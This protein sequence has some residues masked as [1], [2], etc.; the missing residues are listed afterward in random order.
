[1]YLFSHCLCS[2]LPSEIP[3]VSHAVSFILTLMVLYFQGRHEY[4][5][6]PHN[7]SNFVDSCQ[8][9]SNTIL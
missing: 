5:S 8:A 1:M 6:G 4:T 3:T 9:A 7:S 2:P